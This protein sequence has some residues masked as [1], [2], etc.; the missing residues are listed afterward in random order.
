MQANVAAGK[1][2]ALKYFIMQN[3]ILLYTKSNRESVCKCVLLQRQ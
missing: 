2:E 3:F 1:H